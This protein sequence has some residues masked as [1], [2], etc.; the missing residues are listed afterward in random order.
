VVALL[1]RLADRGLDFIQT[2]HLYEFDGERGY[3]LAQ[4]E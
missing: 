3:S 2:A 4:G 1:A